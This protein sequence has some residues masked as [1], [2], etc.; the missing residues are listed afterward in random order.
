MLLEGA[1][2]KREKKVQQLLVGG[3]GERKKKEFAKN[4]ET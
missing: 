4:E 3:L 2:V 1:E